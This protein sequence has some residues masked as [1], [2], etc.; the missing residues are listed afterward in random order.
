MKPQR[1][2]AQ[3]LRI[4]D[5]IE[6]ARREQPLEKTQWLLIDYLTEKLDSNN[7]YIKQH[8]YSYIKQ[9]QNYIKHQEKISKVVGYDPLIEII[10][11]LVKGYKPPKGKVYGM[12]SMADLLRKITKFPECQWEAKIVL[13][14]QGIS[15]KKSIKEI[16]EI[17]TSE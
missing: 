16:K 6:M 2:I 9:L 11:F 3:D 15:N 10:V 14:S 5:A 8:S 4:V 1:R 7:P 12:T 13:V 17:I